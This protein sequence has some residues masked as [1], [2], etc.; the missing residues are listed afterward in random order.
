MPTRSRSASSFASSWCR[1]GPP[2]PQLARSA[3]RRGTPSPNTIPKMSAP[4]S[5][6]PTSEPGLFR[7]FDA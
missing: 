5:P 3:R 7:F 4:L 2:P 6:G 1:R